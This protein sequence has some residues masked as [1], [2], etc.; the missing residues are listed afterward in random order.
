MNTDPTGTAPHGDAIRVPAAILVGLVLAVYGA[1]V[2]VPYALTDEY[3]Q[4]LYI[5]NHWCDW[6]T[7][8]L[9][10]DG[11]PIASF[12]IDGGF[13]LAGGI[14][15][16]GILRAAALAGALSF[17]I[18]L[19]GRIVK[20]GFAVHE[21][22]AIAL[23]A[24][25]SPGMGEY[26]GWA[27]SWPYPFL[28]LFVIWLGFRM[29]DASGDSPGRVF[30][31][32]AFAVGALQFVM[33]TYQPVAGFLVLPGLLM[34]HRGKLRPLVFAIPSLA[35]AFLL[36]R[37]ATYPLIHHLAPVMCHTTRGAIDTDLPGH[38]AYIF[39][40]FFSFMA[41]SWGNLLLPHSLASAAGLISIAAA[42][43]GVAAFARG[44]S[45][46]RRLVA[47][48]LICAAIVISAPQVFLLG[49][50]WAPRTHAPMA[51]ILAI[52]AC[53]GLFWIVGKRRGRALSAAVATLLVLSAGWAFNAGLVWPARRE[54]AIVRTSLEELRDSGAKEA[55]VLVTPDAY[56]PQAPVPIYWHSCYGI[57]SLIL[58]NHMETAEVAREVWPDPAQRPRLLFV[59]A[60]TSD[61]LPQGVPVIDLWGRIMEKPSPA[62]TSTTQ[63]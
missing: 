36:Y 25:L 6:T 11:R 4:L 39:S 17:S 58:M 7:N 14:A 52:L 29:G 33:L 40:H 47:V 32:S 57:V 21:A 24:V 27:V 5:L 50:I 13:R 30:A 59:K 20:A 55:V 35:A 41:S 63:R 26:V 54:Y 19:F 46:W 12:L 43:L 23:V 56:D 10:R 53:Q 16:L 31:D 45:G 48:V 15:G 61:P 44:S 3:G 2:F 34:L 22:F 42:L 38:L 18:Y 9:A 37:V 8:S 60:D 1:C 28:M 62:A 49:D 51:V